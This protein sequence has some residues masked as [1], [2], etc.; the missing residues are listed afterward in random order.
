MKACSSPLSRNLGFLVDELS[1][2][3]GGG[4][5]IP[6]SCTARSWLS[7]QWEP[8]TG[9]GGILLQGSAAVLAHYVVFLLFSTTKKGADPTRFCLSWWRFPLN[10]ISKRERLSKDLCQ[11]IRKVI[12]SPLHILNFHLRILLLAL[13]HVDS[14]IAGTL[15]ADTWALWKNP[16]GHIALK[17]CP[18][19]LTGGVVC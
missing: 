12:T 13:F 9:D 6:R 1:W 14:Y 8:H 15:P 17:I 2:G 19:F 3:P 16:P 7:S 11:W 4:P 18:T 5:P 10:S